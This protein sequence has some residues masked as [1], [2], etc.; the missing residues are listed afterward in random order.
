M[1]EQISK[2]LVIIH[3][4]ILCLDEINAIFPFCEDGE[5]EPCIMII[6]GQFRCFEVEKEAWNK[7]RQAFIRLKLS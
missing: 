1:F 6:Q 3:E 2:N 7:L 5:D 4:V